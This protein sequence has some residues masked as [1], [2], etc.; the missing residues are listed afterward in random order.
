[1]TRLA[2]V[3]GTGRGLGRAIAEELLDAGWAVIGLERRP[4]EKPE[5]RPGLTVIRHDVRAEVPAALH[6]AIGDRA[7]DLLV[8]NAAQGAPGGGVQDADPGAV[9]R[10][11]DIAVAGP[12]RL[13]AALLPSLRR[14]SRPVIVNISSRL[15][16]VTAQARGDFDGFGTSYAYRISKAAQNMLTVSLAQELSPPIRVLAVHPGRLRTEMGRVGADKDPAVAARELLALVDSDD[17]RSPRF[18]SLG[19]PDLEW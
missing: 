11:V 15:G 19:E 5:P 9:L 17:A 2:V 8:N 4:G 1:M 3:S 12:M 6:A 10:S 14:A 13:V 7:V 16:S 18:C